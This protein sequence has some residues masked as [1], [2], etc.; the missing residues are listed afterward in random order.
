MTKADQTSYI[1]L[2]SPQFQ[3]G[4]NEAVDK[5]YLSCKEI[6]ILILLLWGE[7]SLLPS[8]FTVKGIF[9]PPR[10]GVLTT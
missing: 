7:G 4:N 2:P 6:Q 1:K 8:N 3:H 9:L 10:N 5:L